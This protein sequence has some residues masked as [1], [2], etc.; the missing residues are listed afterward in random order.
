MTEAKWNWE[1]Q[2]SIRNLGTSSHN[3]HSISLKGT[4][5][6]LPDFLPDDVY[7]DL[8]I[9]MRYNEILKEKFRMAARRAVNRKYESFA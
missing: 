8:I 7:V 4:V 6:L 1:E 2:S 3:N 5:M 9:V